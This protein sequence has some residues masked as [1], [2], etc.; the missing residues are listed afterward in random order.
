MK[1]IGNLAI[2]CARRKDVTLR[3]EQ[4]RVKVL[5]SGTYAPAAFSAD[6]DDDETILSVIHD[7]IWYNSDK[8][9]IARGIIWLHRKYER[10]LTY[11]NNKAVYIF[12]DLLL[13]RN[14]IAKFRCSSFQR[15]LR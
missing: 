2:V 14:A 11:K 9:I 12:A 6:W 10:M 1:Q 3:I 15:L 8:Q 5:L 4:G 7:V 13:A